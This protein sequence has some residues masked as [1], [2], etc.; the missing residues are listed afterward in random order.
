MYFVQQQLHPNSFQALDHKDLCNLFAMFKVHS[1]FTF[2]HQTSVVAIATGMVSDLSV[3]CDQA[4]DI[5]N[6]AANAT[7]GKTFSEVKLKCSYRVKTISG[8][9]QTVKICGQ[10]VVVNSTLLFSRITCV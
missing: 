4:Y 3:N 9:T 10:S 2:S 6:A 1:L 5:G 8:S 7:N